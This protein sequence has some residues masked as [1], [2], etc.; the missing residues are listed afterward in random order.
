[1]ADRPISIRDIAE[2]ADVSIATVSRVVNGKGR[3]SKDTEARVREIIEQVHYVPNIAA[4]SL[5]TNAYRLIGI[6]VPDIT[7]EFFAKIVQVIQYQLIGLGYA[8][9]ISNTNEDPDL[10][11]IQT[12]MLRS[13]NIAGIIY[14]SGHMP[15]DKKLRNLPT[16]FID[17]KPINGEIH[18][19]SV[20]ES[21]NVL[22]ARLAVRELH[23]HGRRRIGFINAA[24]SSSTHNQRFDGY[25]QAL[26]ELELVFQ[27]DWH[28]QVHQVGYDEAYSVMS[29]FLESGRMIDGL[30]CA[31]DWLAV[32][33]VDAIRHHDLNVP[34]DISVIGFDDISIARYRNIPLTT[35][36]QDITQL[37]TE[38][39]SIL[40]TLIASP[41]MASIHKVI[42]VTLI[43]R[44]TT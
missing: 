4:Q 17:R 2:K 42:P 38:A 10:E 13:Q 29:A 36:H 19:V 11:K 28:M 25:R 8:A 3:Y 32:G 44:S 6:V 23:A 30:F 43:K 40:M 15:V 26:Q 31:T 18:S 22:G 5:K 37:G 24:M 35:I 39:I 41:G 16:V 34:E 14:V 7:N 33:A 9:F 12:D 27:D 21:D 1:M 20:V